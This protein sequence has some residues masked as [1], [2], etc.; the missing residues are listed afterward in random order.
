MKDLVAGAIYLNCSLGELLKDF[1]KKSKVKFW[2]Q[3]LFL[4]SFLA[5]VLFTT[6]DADCVNEHVHLSGPWGKAKFDVLLAASPEARELGLMFKSR[7][8]KSEGM[9]FIYEYPQQVSFW[10]KNTLISLDIL[11]FDQYG[12]L[13]NIAHNTVPGDLT[14]RSSLGPIQFVLEINAG[15]GHSLRLDSGTLLEH[16]ALLSSKKTTSCG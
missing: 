4:S 2:V 1:D 9:L 8:P 5:V 7:L 13:I 15:L 10:M 6:S 14:P 12:E 3:T 16:P 11:F